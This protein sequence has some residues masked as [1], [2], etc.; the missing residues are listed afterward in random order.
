MSNNPPYA[1][2]EL[3]R[4]TYDFIVANCESNMAFGLNALGMVKEQSSLEK[5]VES[6]EQFKALKKK[7]EASKL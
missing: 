2:V 3:D 7:V 5:I 4:E 6:I 1:V